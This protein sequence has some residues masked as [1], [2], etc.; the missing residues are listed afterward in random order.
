MK[1]SSFFLMPVTLLVSLNLSAFDIKNLEGTWQGTKTS[2]MTMKGEDQTT[3]QRQEVKTDSNDYLRK[4]EF[5]QEAYSPNIIGKI[6]GA[7]ANDYFQLR[8]VDSGNSAGQQLMSQETK[9]NKKSVYFGALNP[10]ASE[11]VDVKE[12]SNEQNQEVLSYRHSAGGMSVE[13]HVTIISD[14]QIQ[15]VEVKEIL[16]VK[17]F[18]YF[19][20]NKQ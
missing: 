5:K 11:T 20:L 17:L 15:Y 9:D 4:I 8:I 18:G 3:I 16:G 14:K 7:S 13:Y 10:M 6:L 19:N 1:I 2:Q 12:Y